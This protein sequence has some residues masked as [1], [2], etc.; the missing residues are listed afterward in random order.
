[1]Y[2]RVQNELAAAFHELKNELSMQHFG[3]KYDDLSNQDYIT[4]IDKAV[5]VAISE[6]EPENVGD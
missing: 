4:A 2:I 6:A 3:M 1:M 5:P